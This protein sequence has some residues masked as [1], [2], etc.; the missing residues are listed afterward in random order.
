MKKNYV[1]NVLPMKLLLL[2]LLFLP[3]LKAQSQCPTVPVSPQVICDASLL[4]FGDLDAFAT[5]ASNPIRWYNNPTGGTALPPSQLVRE[6]TYYAGDTTGNCGTREELVVDFTVGPTMQ[7]LE[8]IFCSNEEPTIQS[9][10][11]ESLAANIPTGGTVEIF[12]DFGL[13]DR[14]DPSETIPENANYF[15]VF[16]DSDGCRSQVESG[17]TA[18]FVSPEI[19]TPQT[20]QEFC[21]DTSP[22]IADLDPGTDGNFNWFSDVDS[23]NDPLPPPLPLSTPLVDGTTYFVQANNFFCE[24]DV[25]A[26][27]VSIAQPPMPGMGTTIDFCIDDVPAEDFD[28]FPLLTGTPDATG[29]WTGPTNITNGATGTTNIS[30]LAAGTYAYIYTVSGTAPCP[31]ETATITI[32]INE[33]LT[34]GVPSSLNPLVF[35]LSDAPANFD[36]FTLIDNEDA[37]GLWTQGTSSAD[38]VVDATFDFTT[39]VPG[40]YNFTYSQNIEPNP[41]PEESTTVEVTILADPNAGTAIPAEICENEIVENSPFNL[42]DALDGSQDNNAGIWT[43]ANGAEVS[44]SIDITSFTVADSPFTFTYTIDNGSCTDSEAITIAIL[45][46]PESGNFIGTPFEICEDEVAASPS[47]DLFT[48]LD[49]TQDAN[50][51]WFAGTDATG[52]AVNNPIDLTTLGTG[53]F[54][55]TYSVPAIGSCTD[56][57]VTVTVI[58]TELP[59]AGT[60]TPLI[61][62]ETDR[63]SLSPV[64][65]FDQLADETAGG[66]WADDDSTGA[67]TGS[68]VNLNGLPVGTFN[69]T[70]SITSA[71]C[72]ATS[73]VVI[74]IEEAP[75]A[76]TGTDVEIC[77]EDVAA[78]Q[79]LDLF[80]QLVDNDPGGTWNDDDATGALDGNNVDLSLLPAGVY[81]FTY[82]VAALG[83][84]PSDME[85]VTITINDIAAPIAADTQEFCDSATV[86]DL[87]ATGNNVQWYSDMA[88]TI[89]LSSTDALVDGDS[90]FATQTDATTG[91]ESSIP[92][93]VMVAIF[94]TPNTGIAA[95]II[96]CSDATMVDLFTALDGSQDTGGTWIDTDDT[97]ALNDN[98]FD[99]SAVVTGS[100]TFE[101]LIAGNPPCTDS[102]TITTVTVQDPVSAGNSTAIDLCTDNGMIDLF[103]LLGTADAGGIWSPALNS[104]TGVLDPLID[105]SGTYTY[106]VMNGCN[107]S[108]AT[109]AVSITAAPNAG[110]DA[111]IM[112]C[113]IDDPFDL[114]TQLGG[115]PDATG[116]WSPELSSGSNIFDP[117]VDI[118]GTYTYT[119]TAAAPCETDES[120]QI[121]III[122]NTE[123]PTVVSNSLDFCA[124]DAP[125]VM[126]LDAAVTGT[127]ILWYDTIDST[128]PLSDDTLLVNGTIY[129]ATQTGVT[130]CESDA[131][132]QVTANVADAP[133]PSLS[134][135]G[136]LFC[137]ND[138]PTLLDLT[139]NINEFDASSNNV[140]WYEDQVSTVPVPVS[141]LLAGDTNYFAAIIDPSTGCESSVRL[142]VTPDLTACDAVEIPDGF[143]PNND[144]VND[145][146]DVDNLGFLFPNFELEVYNRNGI[147]VYRGVDS[148]PRFNGFSNQQALLSDGELPVGVYFYILN[149][150]DDTTRPVQG[151]IYISR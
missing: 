90:Y 110:T 24:S 28:L 12:S 138:F 45:P 97:G 48:L 36:L 126:D 136:E 43:D 91:C 79:L 105:P 148:T 46:A 107:T 70:Y 30:A 38:P 104:N 63:A 34:S 17:S 53:T 116:T 111:A 60:P 113:R 8:A 11:N 103:T 84:C 22:T 2:L 15:I 40:V 109:V 93:T 95:P 125:I 4:T 87:L 130:G 3:A 143:S 124:S 50:G 82:N 1:S 72:T 67:L 23:S 64:D 55:F 65:L 144:G 88:L 86:A 44:S 141:T 20:V 58:I 106:T 119:V 137:I 80:D 74:T 69:F 83:T 112:I 27:T 115:T 29:T 121:E 57:D 73:T 71:S 75:E 68:R 142:L 147:L 118:A 51:N 122:E 96:V 35:C 49:G 37:G 19:P 92:V 32:V 131:R 85:T 94:Q 117:T 66:D 26:V 135:D 127:M 14:R 62:C 41:C 77:A 76:G 120:A 89:L 16:V 108:T 61:L 101:Y 31:D 78:G 10:I 25:T 102:S 139:Q 123:A 132:V 145:T 5:A 149:F 81:N 146:F 56:E 151:R 99:S 42:F 39:L 59:E 98:I 114:T 129:F 47:F 33:I 140:V 7:S 13:T 54:D 128:T 9:Y 21:S 133:T 18:V 100:Y 134:I 150:N 52:T 6:G